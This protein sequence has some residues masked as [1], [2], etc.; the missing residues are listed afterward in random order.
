MLFVLLNH[1][2]VKLVMIAIIAA[3]IYKL[4]VRSVKTQFQRKM[5]Q[6]PFSFSWETVTAGKY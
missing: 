3:S 1:F 6:S 4:Y 5:L 2:L